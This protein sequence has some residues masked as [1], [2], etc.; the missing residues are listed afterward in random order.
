M[1]YPGA[2]RR[3]EIAA[4]LQARG[5]QEGAVHQGEQVLYQWD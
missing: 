3:V 2:A 5:V 4:C 1:S